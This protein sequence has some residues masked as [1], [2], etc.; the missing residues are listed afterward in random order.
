MPPLTAAQTQLEADLQTL[1]NAAGVLAAECMAGK[2]FRYEPTEVPIDREQDA[3]AAP[4]LDPDTTAREGY[5]SLLGGP[6]E[7][8]LHEDAR[9]EDAYVASLSKE[10]QAAFQKAFQ[11][12]RRQSVRIEGGGLTIPADGCLADGRK[13]VGGDAFAD[14]TA[15]ESA[16]GN[17]IG[18]AADAV[19]ASAEYAE[20]QQT[21]S[22]CM[23]DAG[24]HYE[25][26]GDA[27]GDALEKYGMNGN[28]ERTVSPAE[29]TM[30]TAD[31][32]CRQSSKLVDVSIRVRRTYERKAMS[33]VESTMSS[34]LE[35]RKAV[36][37]KA[38]QALR[39]EGGG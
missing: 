30:A 19:D 31:A 16:I 26:D 21:W 3:Y 14:W 13:A 29:K 20:A 12:T 28:A 38:E 37:N 8:A 39:G 15:T 25:T 7:G 10:Q 2:G 27:L 18:L 1:E 4:R 22:D 35:S 6:R 23:D 32:K 5:G 9:T 36:L 34:W 33:T 24:F 17:A 11:G